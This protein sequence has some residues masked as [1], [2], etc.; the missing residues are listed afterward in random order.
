MDIRI[1]RPAII[2]Q[3]KNMLLRNYRPGHGGARNISRLG[4]REEDSSWRDH[5]VS[6]GTSNRVRVSMV[7]VSGRETNGAS[8]FLSIFWDRFPAHTASYFDYAHS[9]SGSRS[10]L[11]CLRDLF[12]TVSRENRYDLR[13]PLLAYITA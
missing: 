9:P 7:H 10:L 5:I 12:H 8:H 6:R 1:C 13:F 3:I 11:F 2:Q 4:Y